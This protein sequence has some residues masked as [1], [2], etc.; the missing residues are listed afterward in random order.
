ME[1]EEGSLQVARQGNEACRLR[2]SYKGLGPE[3]HAEFALEL[4]FLRVTLRAITC[5]LRRAPRRAPLTLLKLFCSL[6]HTTIQMIQAH[7]PL[8][9]FVNDSVAQN[10][11]TNMAYRSNM[12]ITP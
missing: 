6:P 4:H 12:Y 5:D 10:S 1:D 7:S 11:N 9:F 2:I 8:S 3:G